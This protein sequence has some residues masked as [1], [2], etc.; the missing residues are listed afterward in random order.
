MSSPPAKTDGLKA[1]EPIEAADVVIAEDLMKDLL[2][3]LVSLLNF[4]I[5]RF[6]GYWD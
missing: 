4:S 2:E 6:L 3:D 5:K 1:R